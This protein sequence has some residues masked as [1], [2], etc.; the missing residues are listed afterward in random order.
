MMVKKHRLGLALGC[1]LIIGTSPV[2]QSA[3]LPWK[4]ANPL[5]RLFGSS[6]PKGETRH[7][8]RAARSAP[9]KAVPALSAVPV[10]DARPDR[11]DV[12]TTA[13]AAAEEKPAPAE[14]AAP[15]AQGAGESEASKQSQF[16]K[17]TEATKAN[18]ATKSGEANKSGEPSNAGDDVEAK[19]IPADSVPKP[20]AA[21]EPAPVPVA[22][23]ADAEA[24]TG[25]ASAETAGSKDAPADPAETAKMPID[26][27]PV[28]AVRP[29]AAGDA[30]KP[31]AAPEAPVPATPPA[32]PESAPNSTENLKS[33]TATVTPAA[34]VLAAAAIEDAEL[35]E[36]ELKKR[37]VEFTVGESIS[38][39]DCG[40][41]RPIN[42]KRLS[43]GIA[44]SPD[45]QFLCR[46]A[47]A[48]DDWM[49]A[50]VLPAVKAELPGRKLSQFR[51]AS[52]YV[53]RP[54]AS[55]SG[56]SEHARGSAIDIAAFVFDKGEDVG[57]EAQAE[58]SPEAKFQAA[59]RTAACGPFKTV[60]GPGTDPDHATHFHLDIAARKT[61]ATYCK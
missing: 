28:P 12:V 48:L 39:G 27:I 47:L 21:P 53:C 32:E 3:S 10:P 9:A 4:D 8:P 49:T 14:V 56:I 30:A 57:V 26:D 43:S 42:V 2:A 16:A 52:T 41:L 17:A 36:G 29:E 58:G 22:A 51:H 61:G 18:E 55:E 20:A 50:G 46:T 19:D 23:P 59:V 54:R 33:R 44:V 37:G 1:L 40:V 11:A 6:E 45:T 15:A 60:L 13:P 5:E 35:C 31:E 7:R 38:E 34:S 24:A 25:G